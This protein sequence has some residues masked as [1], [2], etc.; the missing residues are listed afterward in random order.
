[1]V[2]E[3]KMLT[4]F[5]RTSRDNAR[6]PMQWDATHE[7]GFTSGQASM[8]VNRN[9]ATI[10]VQAQR[11]DL[12]SIWHTYQ[13]VIALRKQFKDVF[14]YGSY[15]LYEPEHQDVYAYVR[16]SEDACVLVVCNFRATPTRL[17]ALPVYSEVLCSNYAHAP[18]TQLQPYEAFVVVLA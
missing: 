11:E 14:V 4:H 18:S 7:A 2:P 12:D 3:S 13:K 8:K 17:S 6:T 15:D 5:R 10:N 9:Y 1:S 16:K